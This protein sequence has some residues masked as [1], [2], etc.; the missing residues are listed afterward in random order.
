MSI[1]ENGG[2]FTK[3]LVRCTMHRTPPGGIMLMASTRWGERRVG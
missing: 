1:Q 2:L 3:R